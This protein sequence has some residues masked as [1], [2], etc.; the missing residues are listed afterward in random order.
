MQHER[1]LKEFEIERLLNGAVLEEHP[2]KGAYWKLDAKKAAYRS[3]FL[4]GLSI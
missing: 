4:H 1:R 3:S 2:R